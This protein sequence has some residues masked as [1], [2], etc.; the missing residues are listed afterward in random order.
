MS[1]LS[2]FDA[3]PSPEPPPPVAEAQGHGVEIPRP[4]EW[5]QTWEEK[6]RL[7]AMPPASHFEPT[8]FEFVPAFRMAGGHYEGDKEVGKGDIRASYS[9]DLISDKCVT[10]RPF[11]YRGQLWVSTGGRLG[12]C[13]TGMMLVDPKRYKG[14]TTK[15]PFTLGR[16]YDGLIVR[17]KGVAYVLTGARE[18]YIDTPEARA[19]AEE[20]FNH[21]KAYRA[22]ALD[23]H[24]NGRQMLRDKDWPDDLDA[25]YKNNYC[26]SK[27]KL[28]DLLFDRCC[29]AHS[30]SNVAQVF[31]H[32]HPLNNG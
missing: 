23:W 20:D 4:G 21:S 2:L 28:G 8:P 19:K 5:V 17:S 22:Q 14:P 26:E 30:W 29:G 7:F 16:G 31:D 24:L 6:G 18:F 12:F 32:W 3:M 9:S 11:T 25:I 1:Q 27:D 10:R 13:T 15:K